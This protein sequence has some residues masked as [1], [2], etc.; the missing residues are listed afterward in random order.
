MRRVSLKLINIGKTMLS[1][2]RKFRTLS[3]IPFLFRKWNRGIIRLRVLIGRCGRFI[4][5]RGF[6][7]LM[8]RVRVKFRKFR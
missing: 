1:V 6:A 4:G 3:L 7:R 2:L 8:T 5:V